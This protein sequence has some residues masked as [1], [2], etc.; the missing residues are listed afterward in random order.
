MKKSYV[1]VLLVLV[2]LLAA[3][4]QENPWP[5]IS[6]TDDG[7]IFVAYERFIAKLDAEGKRIWTFPE[8]DDRDALFYAPPVVDNGTVYAG[9]Y[10]GN[11]YAIDRETGKE[12]WSYKVEGTKLF[13]IANFGGS[14]DRVIAPIAIAENVLFVPDEIG[15][16]ALN[17]ETGKLLNWK[18][19]SDR[20]VWSQPIYL[21]A[22]DNHPAILFVAS[23]DHYLYALD[24]SEIDLEDT[25]D[26]INDA[27]DAKVLWKTDLKGAAAGQPTYDVE[28][29]ILFAGTFGSKMLAVRAEDGE[30]LGEYET[31]GW[32]WEGPAMY[33]NTL[34]FGDVKG[35]LYAVTFEDDQFQQVWS[36]QV[37][38]GKLRAKP[39]VTEEL[40]IVA[41][42]DQTIYAVLREDGKDEWAREMESKTLSELIPLE[43]EEDMLLVTGTENKDE[44]V[45]AL[46]LDNGNER[47]S[48]KHED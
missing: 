24:V 32:V 41:S 46:R 26:K 3:C 18:L 5:G 15:V 16:F 11:V 17:K 47:W 29:G 22:N 12:I 33:D 20:A 36:Q 30:I 28:R 42:D 38:K 13:G 31:R 6:K 40:V 23:L 8:K 2:L 39:L 10:K 25:V 48:Y 35:Y 9:D 7:E 14:T 34:Y 19:D 44:L 43:G 21:A 4:S 37:A 27:N 45:V 1:L